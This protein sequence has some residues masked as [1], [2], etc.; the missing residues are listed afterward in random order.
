MGNCL[1]TVDRPEDEGEVVITVK[2]TQQ[3]D[4]NFARKMYLKGLPRIL[5]VRDNK[6][7]DFNYLSVQCFEKIGRECGYKRS[8]M[9]TPTFF[10]GTAWFVMTKQEN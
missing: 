1:C 2:D 7:Y 6:C 9:N 8:N 3:L 5:F 4:E 10:V